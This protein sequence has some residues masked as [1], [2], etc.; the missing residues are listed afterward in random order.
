MSGL[1]HKEQRVAVFVDVQNLYY[2]AKHMYKSKVNF[3]AILK[4]AVKG[5]QLVRA[6]AYVI[7]ADVKDE[8]NFHGALENIGF[9][10]KAKELQVFQGGNK[11]GDWDVGIAMDMLRLAPKVD[12]VILISGD[13]DFAEC[14]KYVKA[15]GCRA[16]SLGFK[17]TSSVLLL[18]EVDEFTPIDGK[19]FLIK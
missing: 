14:V 16:E 17:K 9:E 6:F 11:K 4:E 7:K 19:K 12:V 8:K 2:S 5:R 18:N 10:V 15:I 1:H 13:G 3:N